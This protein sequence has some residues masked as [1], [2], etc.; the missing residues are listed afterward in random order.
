MNHLANYKRHAPALIAS[1][2]LA[3]LAALAA[4]GPTSAA[5]GD[6]AAEA[7]ALRSE[8]EVLDQRLKVL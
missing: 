7:N 6:A 5:S 4:D 8:I 2:L 1:L 3:P